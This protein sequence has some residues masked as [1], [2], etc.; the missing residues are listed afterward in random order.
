[1]KPDFIMMNHWQ[2]QA[3]N[4]YNPYED[5]QILK[6]KTDKKAAF[7]AQRE[8]HTYRHHFANQRESCYI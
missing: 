4:L 7:L 2:A 1:M 3:L 8:A 6:T 5:T